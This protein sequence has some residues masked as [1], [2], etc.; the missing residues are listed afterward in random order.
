MAN[1]PA[2]RKA[3]GQLS[4]WFGEKAY[5]HDVSI[6]KENR[7][8]IAEQAAAALPQD[9]KLYCER[10]AQGVNRYLEDHPR[11]QGLEYWLL[12]AKAE[13]WSCKDSILI[14]MELAQQLTTS[15][16]EKIRATAWQQHLPKS[17]ARF[18]FP[19]SHRWNKPYFSNKTAA[20]SSNN[21]STEVE[22]SPP[23][24]AQLP[25][26]EHWLK[27]FKFSGQTL[28]PV[29]Q[30][31]STA[32]GSN[33]W[34][35]R[36]NHGFFLAND[37]HLS[38]SV[39]GIWYMTRLRMSKEQ[40]IVG[41]ALPGIPGIILGMNPHYS[42]AFTNTGEDVDNIL[43]EEIE[44][45]F[46]R[47]RAPDG[48]LIWRPLIKKEFPIRV[49]GEAKPRMVE[50]LFTHRGPL[51]QD[52]LLGDAFYSRQWLALNANLLRL[53]ISKLILGKSIVDVHSAIDDLKI[54]SQN[55]LILDRLGNMS[56]RTSG[57]G[58]VRGHILDTPH[59]QLAFEGEWL[60]FEEPQQRRRLDVPVSSSE[61]TFLATANAR[62]W[63][64][65]HY[66]NWTPD[67]RMDRIE[68]Y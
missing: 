58:I 7:L 49:K 5:L 41:T 28:E 34:S 9:E 29:Q 61:K 31:P 27:P 55:V 48:K 46:Y 19:Q 30:D 40:W 3:S 52:A 45:D 59:T 35:Y 56:Y 14:L 12:G 13:A 26:K 51:F 23:Q 16:D 53:P 44:G 43:K 64:E 24:G 65:A 68:G 50:G 63:E 6:Q 60:G 67:D 4:E 54:P 47:D 18:L 62:V 17:W 10:Y 21:P 25:P 11:R 22:E 42:W 36:S 38:H 32:Y 66:H 20:N 39:P 2:A 15:K 1:G 57:T 37:P 33:N 8:A